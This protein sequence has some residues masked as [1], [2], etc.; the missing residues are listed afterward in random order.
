MEWTTEQ[1]VDMR[2][3]ALE[4]LERKLPPED[5]AIYGWGMGY[6]WAMLERQGVL[7]HQSSEE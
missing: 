7:P 5:A 1:M 2:D 4:A 6:I 3:A